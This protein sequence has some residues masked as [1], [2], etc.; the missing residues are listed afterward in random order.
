V[1]VFVS[2]VDDWRRLLVDCGVDCVDSVDCVV[3]MVVVVVGSFGCDWWLLVVGVVVVVGSRGGR[4]TSSLCFAW[5][6][7]LCTK[8]GSPLRRSRGRLGLLHE[9][10]SRDGFTATLHTVH[11]CTTQYIFTFDTG[12]LERRIEEAGVGVREERPQEQQQQ[13]N[14]EQEERGCGW[15][16]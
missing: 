2:G 13:Q 12:F 7:T 3:H 16:R 11:A 1:C 14:K 8:K 15:H 10:T 4:S 6:V 5:W 9:N